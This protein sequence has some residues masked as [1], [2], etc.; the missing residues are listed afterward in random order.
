VGAVLLNETVD[1]LGER[2]AMVLSRTRGSIETFAREAGIPIETLQQLV[3]QSRPALPLEATAGLMR[4]LRCSPDWLLGLSPHGAP[5][6]AELRRSLAPPPKVRESWVG[7]RI[8]RRGFPRRLRSVCLGELSARFEAEEA[9]QRA[10]SNAARAPGQGHHSEAIPAESR[11]V[12]ARLASLLADAKIARAELARVTGLSVGAVDELCRGRR[13]NVDAREV[14]V[15]AKTLG[16]RASWLLGMDPT[17]PTIEGV[18][19][20]FAQRGGRR[21]VVA[22]DAARCARGPEDL[23]ALQDPARLPRP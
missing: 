6:Y 20:S 12:G 22:G 5:P 17:T 3:R 9:R 16:C 8:R 1:E 2:I 23:V 11:E 10:R 14:A 18:W 19:A 21:R 15:I 13:K 7:R 4:A